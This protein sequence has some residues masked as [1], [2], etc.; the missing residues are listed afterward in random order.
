[1]W[2]A[3]S[4]TEGEKNKGCGGEPF[5]L[6]FFSFSFVG[7]IYS[8]LGYTPWP[9]YDETSNE[10]SY[11]FD[12]DEINFGW[13]EKIKHQ[14]NLAAMMTQFPISITLKIF[15]FEPFKINPV[16]R[17][18]FRFHHIPVRLYVIFLWESFP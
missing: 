9:E 18:K 11:V 6:N 17:L 14:K 12:L 3:L 16:L 8:Y 5:N 15:I 1:M 7:P 2:K 10:S 4:G 13:F